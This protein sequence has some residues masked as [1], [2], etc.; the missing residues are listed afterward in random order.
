MV[1][2]C[3]DAVTTALPGRPPDGPIRPCARPCAA[4]EKDAF[5][6]RPYGFVPTHRVFPPAEIVTCWGVC[7]TVAPCGSVKVP[8]TGTWSA[9]RPVTEKIGGAPACA[10]RAKV[11]RS[12]PTCA[13]TAVVSATRRLLRTG[14]CRTCTVKPPD[15]T[16]AQVNS[17]TACM[18]YRVLSAVRM[19][20]SPV[21]LA[22]LLGGSKPPPDESPALLEGLESQPMAPHTV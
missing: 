12:P 16:V 17:P 10:G 1:N 22:P 7:T 20:G 21:L 5:T 6:F 9:A 14:C 4:A 18:S 19:C 8:T 11:T 15:G 2:F 3:P 13:A